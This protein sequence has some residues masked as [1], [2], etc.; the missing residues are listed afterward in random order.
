[1]T[2]PERTPREFKIHRMVDEAVLEKMY[3]EGWQTDN[4]QWEGGYLRG[5]FSRQKGETPPVSTPDPKPT[6]IAE[7]EPEG[8]PTGNG[9]GNEDAPPADTPPPIKPPPP[10]PSEETPVIVVTANP[11]LTDFAEAMR[12]IQAD[13]TLSPQEKVE[14]LKKAGD[15]IAIHKA[16]IAGEQAW[17]MWN[18]LYPVKPNPFQL[19]EGVKA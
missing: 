5:I 10:P 12:R 17:N 11:P 13:K 19:M 7:A 9:K 4:L 14:A 6:L 18:T 2:T 8:T 16:R 3:N 1:M 15:E